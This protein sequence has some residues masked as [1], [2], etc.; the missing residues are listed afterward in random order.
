MRNVIANE[1]NEE[2]LL[3]N[4]KI[5]ASSDSDQSETEEES[6]KETIMYQNINL[7]KIIAETLNSIIEESN[8]SKKSKKTIPPLFMSTR[9]KYLFL[10][11]Y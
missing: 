11:I 3:S 5:K 6:S 7:L 4:S 10:I 2:E 9:P 1:V 8:K